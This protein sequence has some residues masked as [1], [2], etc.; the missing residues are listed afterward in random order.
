MKKSKM[1]GIDAVANMAPSNL[2]RQSKPRHTRLI[3]ATPPCTF[4]M[5]V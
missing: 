1:I 4:I 5:H 2:H 3:A